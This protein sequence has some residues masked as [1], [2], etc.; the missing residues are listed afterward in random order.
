MQGVK[1]IAKCNYEYGCHFVKTIV[2]L[3]WADCRWLLV[4]FMDLHFFGLGDE[5]SAF[6]FV[7]LIG[8]LKPSWSII[9]A[10]SRF[11]LRRASTFVVGRIRGELLLVDPWVDPPWV[12]VMYILLEGVMGVLVMGVE[13]YSWS[14][15]VTLVMGRLLYAVGVNLGVTLITLG[16]AKIIQ[17][18]NLG[19]MDR[20][21]NL[22]C[23]YY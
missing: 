17:Y 2:A 22:E 12:G 7:P 14:V 15:L 10:E 21:Q 13:K 3:D 5:K 20:Q 11:S 6:L 4:D 1:V 9:A 16:P 8:V 23:M 19:T 18:Y